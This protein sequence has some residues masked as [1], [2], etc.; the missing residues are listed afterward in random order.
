MSGFRV[1]KPSLCCIYVTGLHLE[2][3]TAAAQLGTHN[4]LQSMKQH[5]GVTVRSVESPAHTHVG[6]RNL[7]T[8][9]K[10]ITVRQKTN[11]TILFCISYKPHHPAN[12][13]QS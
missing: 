6:D 4:V 13:L 7:R 9:G 10:A 1:R 3:N 12:V 2:H 5:Q 8:K 11:N